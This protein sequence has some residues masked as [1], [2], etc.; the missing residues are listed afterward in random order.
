MQT[1][2]DRF[3]TDTATILEQEVKG[4]G[5]QTFW[6]GVL[7]IALG[8]VGIAL[9]PLLAITTVDLVSLILFIGGGFWFWHA[10]THG[11]GVMRWLK[12]LLLS[13]AGILMFASPLAGAAA[14]ALLLSFYLMLD[15]FGSFALAYDLRPDR[16][17]GWMAANG[18]I[19]MVL[20]AFFTFSWPA[21]SAV[22][23]GLFVGVSLLFDGV[24]LAAIGWSLRK[25]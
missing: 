19:D 14:L 24:A 1:I 7:L 10:W 4:F 18:V 13:V 11:G 5:R 9:P 22:V 8:V 17:W 15:A 12:P 6:V 2:D 21:S 20:V 16:G 23:V 25:S 3:V